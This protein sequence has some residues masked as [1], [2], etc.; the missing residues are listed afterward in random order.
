MAWECVKLRKLD[1]NR[2]NDNLP[3]NI[4][5]ERIYDDPNC[6]DCKRQEMP[7]ISGILF[8]FSKKS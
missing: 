5:D 3:P 4:S 8:V 7:I 2:D 1:I 6:R